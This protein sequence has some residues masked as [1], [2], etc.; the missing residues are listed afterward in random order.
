MNDTP[1]L[2]DELLRVCPAEA[3]V[4]NE[5]KFWWYLNMKLDERPP[6][7]RQLLYSL[8]RVADKF[9]HHAENETDK[10]VLDLVDRTVRHIRE[11][12]IPEAKRIVA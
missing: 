12:L 3:D 5:I 8:R 1:N 2:A 6:S 7:T 4:Q 11:R 9:E 10:A